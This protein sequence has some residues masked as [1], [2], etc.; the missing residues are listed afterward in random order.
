MLPVIEARAPGKL[1]IVGEYAVLHGAPGIPVAVD[2]PARASWNPG[3]ARTANFSFRRRASASGFTGIRPATDLAGES[4]GA[5]GLP[6]ESCLTTLGAEG[7][8]PPAAGPSACRIELDTAAFHGRSAE[9]THQARAGFERCHTVAL[10]GALLKFGQAASARA[11]ADRPLLRGPSSAAGWQRQRDRCG[12]AVAGG[13]ISIEL[14]ADDRGPRTSDLT[15]PGDLHMLAIWSATARRHRRCW[16]G[17]KTIVD[18]RLKPV[19]AHGALGDIA[20]RTLSAW[21]HMDV[22]AV[23]ASLESYA[24][25]LQKL[26]QDAGIGILSGGHVAMR[27]I[28]RAHGAVYKPSGAGGGDFG[29]ALT[30]SGQVMEAVARDFSTRGYRCLEAGFCA[31]DSRSRPRLSRDSGSTRRQDPESCDPIANRCGR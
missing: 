18:S 24:S 25:A 9:V 31:P 27:E 17:C 11:T 29:V 30:A 10:M 1:V 12:T 19:A 5:L 16:L 23:L 6:L 14:S 2:V 7:L 20:S 8:W 4:P 3:P 15:W 28:A 21:R 13:V 22:A 26:D